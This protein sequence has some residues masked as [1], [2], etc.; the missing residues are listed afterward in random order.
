LARMYKGDKAYTKNPIRLISCETGKDVN[1]FAQNL[2]NKLGR[3]VIA[4]SDTVWIHPNGKITI[5]PNAKL[6]S[7]KW[8]SYYPKKVR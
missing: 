8:M 2:A 7:G 6:N 4:P 5:G 3:K 1:G